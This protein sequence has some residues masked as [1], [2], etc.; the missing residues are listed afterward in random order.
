MVS[1]S[2][3]IQSRVSNISYDLSPRKFDPSA[4][5]QYQLIVSVIST[6]Y[7]VV[8]PP[9]TSYISSIEL[10]HSVV[11]QS[12]ASVKGQIPL[13]FFIPSQKSEV[14]TLNPTILSPDRVTYCQL[15]S[16]HSEEISCKSSLPNQTHLNPWKSP[17]SPSSSSS[18]QICNADKSLSSARSSD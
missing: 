4:S 17:G 13:I 16:S 6:V 5:P 18:M 3:L 7:V 15:S 9:I 11:A 1:P 8:P 2:K 10:A 12:G 14:T